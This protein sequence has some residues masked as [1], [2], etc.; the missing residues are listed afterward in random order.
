MSIVEA[1]TRQSVPAHDKELLI[2]EA[3][4]RTRRR[5]WIIG[6]A[7][8]I[9][10]ASTL[11]IVGGGKGV[12]PTRSTSHSLAPTRSGVSS[13]HGAQSPSILGGQSV[14]SIWPWVERRRGSLR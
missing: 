3:R 14:L 8:V 11:A 5:R 1:P 9:V 6:L 7:L 12:P 2:R 10:V 13:G 4:K